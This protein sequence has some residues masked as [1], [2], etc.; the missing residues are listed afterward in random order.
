MEQKFEFVKGFSRFFHI[1]NY[2]IF[3]P[4]FLHTP[5]VP[6][7]L[8]RTAKQGRRCTNRKGIKVNS[9]MNGNSNGTGR[10]DLHEEWGEEIPPARGVFDGEGTEEASSRAGMEPL[11]DSLS[12]TFEEGLR[13]LEAGR[14]KEAGTL[15]RLVLSVR[16]TMPTACTCWA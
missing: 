7:P 12:K 5:P 9:G 8:V 15:F 2:P 3:S 14:F 11:G 13:R 4:H 16:P 10:F 6:S 1:L